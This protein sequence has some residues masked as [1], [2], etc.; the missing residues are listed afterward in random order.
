[1]KV[2]ASHNGLEA[3]RLAYAMLASGAAPLDAL[4][5]GISRIED[6]PEEDTVGYGGLPNEEGI[7]ELDAA[8]MDGPTHQAGAVAALQN[9]RHPT[10]V[11]R[12]VM[13]RTSRVLLVG[14][15]ALAF[16]KANGF[17]EEDLLTDA[18]RAKWLRWKRTRSPIDD[19]LPLD[20]CRAGQACPDRTRMEPS[21]SPIAS[22]WDGRDFE[23]PTGTVHVAIRVDN[24]DMYCATS[25]SGHAFKLPG[26]V[27]DSPIVGAGLYV[28]NGVGT[29]GS[30]G[31]GEA[32]MQNLSS[33]AAVE[34]MRGGAAPH[35]AGLAV[36]QRLVARTSSTKLDQDGRPSFNIRLF[37]MT[38]DGAHGGVCLFGPEQIAVTDADGTRLEPCIPLIADHVQHDRRS[39]P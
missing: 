22:G 1:M 15:G 39:L 19:W 10:Q 32:N 3:T 33:Y 36:L 12:L 9:I 2:I 24:G 28:D 38:K 30:I 11:A 25:T 13:E 34:A 18:A 21:P 8:I 23:R 14:A 37:L 7:V 27:G 5:A 6:D 26:R 31:W 4:V 20:A 17:R 16:A 29:C 35:D